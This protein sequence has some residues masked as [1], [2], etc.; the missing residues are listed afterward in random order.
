MKIRNVFWHNV[1]PDSCYQR[2]HDSISPSVSVFRK[3]VRFIC[4]HYTPISVFDFLN[5][6]K[7]NKPSCSYARPPIL[8]GF[9]DGFRNVINYAL[10]VLREFRVPAVFFVLGEILNNPDF[11]PWYV[12]VQHMLRR[13]GQ[14]RI[15][16]NGGRYSLESDQ[17]K[18]M[19][20]KHVK[21]RFKAC[22]FDE[23]SHE[24]LNGLS[25]SLNVKRPQVSDLDEDLRF[26][27]GDDLAGFDSSNL[28]T[29]GSHAM[30]HR[31]LGNLAYEEQVY[32]L[33]R[34]DEELRRHCPSYYPVIAYPDGSFNKDT[35]AVAKGIY[36][37]GF[38]VF[39]NSSYRDHYAYPRHSLASESVKN[40]KYTLSSSRMKYMLPLKKAIT[41]WQ[42]RIHR[43]G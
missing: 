20:R 15:V 29:V 39:L 38:A 40:L 25:M 37:F 2:H 32:E 36:K 33:K 35:T 6:V 8:L 30:T 7:E 5:I 43:Y 17:E 34:S 14:K 24:L 12:E 42:E 3:Q 27:T 4:D 9:D 11:I 21:R 13:T 1:V 26:V 22:S 23:N 16:F 28:F 10:P 41:M 19:F 18:R 31:N